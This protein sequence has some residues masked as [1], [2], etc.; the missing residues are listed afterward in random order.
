[1][2]DRKKIEGIL[3]QS[4]VLCSCSLWLVKV[5]GKRYSYVCGRTPD[6][7]LIEDITETAAGKSYK[8][9]AQRESGVF[10]DGELSLLKETGEVIEKHI[11]Q[12]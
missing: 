5:I 2:E 6:Y 3:E 10:S 1:M 7:P 8:L 9:L 11:P 12:H 4:S